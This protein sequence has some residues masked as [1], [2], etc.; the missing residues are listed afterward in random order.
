MVKVLKASI[1][2]FAL[3]LVAAAGINAQAPAATTSPT[4]EIIT[5]S[6]GQTLY[7]NKVPILFNVENFEIVDYSVNK[8][9]TAGQGHIHVWLDDAKP[10]AETAAKIIEDTYTFSDIPYGKHTLTAELVN[11]NH[12]PLNPPQKVTVTFNNE[13]IATPEAAATSGFDKKTALV[14]LVVVALVIVAAWWY[15]KD[16]DEDE[17][18]T[19]ENPPAG[20][21]KKKTAKR[22]TTKKKKK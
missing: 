21:P 2:S 6:E 3:L 7:G 9:P 14:I 8:T 22:K 10:T 19:E 17:M 13:Q 4:F 1:L 11:N 5:P 18:A 15:T 16:E 12:Q 20:G